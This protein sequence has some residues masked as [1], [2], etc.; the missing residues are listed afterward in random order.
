MT[1]LKGVFLAVSAAQHHQI[2]ALSSHCGRRQ[3]V[4]TWMRSSSLTGVVRGAAYCPG[5]DCASLVRRHWGER[6]L[7]VSRFLSVSSRLHACRETVLCRLTAR[8][9]GSPRCVSVVSYCGRTYE[10][11]RD[12]RYVNQTTRRMLHAFYPSGKREGDESAPAPTHRA[13]PTRTGPHPGGTVPTAGDSHLHRAVPQGL[14]HRRNTARKT[15]VS[16]CRRVRVANRS[17]CGPFGDRRDC[18]APA[19]LLRNRCAGRRIVPSTRSLEPFRRPRAFRRSGQV[20][21]FP[22]ESSRLFMEVRSRMLPSKQH[23]AVTSLPPAR[24]PQQGGK[25]HEKVFHTTTTNPQY[26]LVPF[27]SLV[28]TCAPATAVALPR[29]HFGDPNLTHHGQ[30]VRGPGQHI[31]DRFDFRKRPAAQTI[32]TDKEG[33]THE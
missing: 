1:R 29:G 31:T 20:V 8:M 32:A 27:W 30:A 24:R 10:P 22:R 6:P 25:Y 17:R 4:L 33:A 28:G 13:G 18:P 12:E 11:W 23:S 5:Q 7:G 2:A 26:R 16:T 14:A 15:T 9:S 21:R 19:Q 3:I